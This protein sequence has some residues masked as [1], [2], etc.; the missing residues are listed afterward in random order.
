MI[1]FVIKS[2]FSDKLTL[3][4]KLHTFRNAQC[5][6]KHNVTLTKCGQQKYQPKF[7]FGVVNGVRKVPPSTPM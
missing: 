2:I 6:Q 7:E 5:L 4:R 3:T 1:F